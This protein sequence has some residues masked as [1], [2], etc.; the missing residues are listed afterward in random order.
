[1]GNLIAWYLWCDER[2]LIDDRTMVWNELNKPELLASARLKG[3][4]EHPVHLLTTYQNMVGSE[5]A[6]MLLEILDLSHDR[7][8]AAIGVER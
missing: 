6:L 7:R 2:E 4:S 3:V 1:M 5:K 8:F